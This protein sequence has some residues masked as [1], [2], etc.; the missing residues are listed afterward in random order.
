MIVNVS[1]NNTVA[2]RTLEIEVTAGDIFDS[3]SFKQKHFDD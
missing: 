1:T 2:N 3:F